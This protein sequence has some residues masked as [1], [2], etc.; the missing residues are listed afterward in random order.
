MRSCASGKKRLKRESGSW[1]IKRGNLEMGKGKL[2]RR[3][4]LNFPFTFFNFTCCSPN[5]NR[6]RISALRGLR[7]KPLDDRAGSKI[8]I[9]EFEFWE[10]APPGLEPRLF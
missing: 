9:S 5:G 4:K 1:D 10:A 3:S 6:T 7:P 2:A 8:R